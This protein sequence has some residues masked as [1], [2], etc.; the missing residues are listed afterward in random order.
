MNG[1]VENALVVG[2]IF[3]PLQIDII[4]VTVC[5]CGVIIWCMNLRG[6]GSLELRK[7]TAYK[8]WF[9]GESRAG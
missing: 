6:G 4:H 5:M 7:S 2:S 3:L 1:S 8:M 9:L